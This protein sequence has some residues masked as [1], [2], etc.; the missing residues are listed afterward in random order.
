MQQIIQPNLN[1]VGTI[2]NCL[3]YARRVYGL[4]AKYPT[5]WK[6]WQATKYKHKDQNFPDVSVPCWFSYISGGVNYGHVVVYVPKKGFYSS[7][8]QKGTTR[9]VL[10]SISEIERIYHAKF[11]GWSE[12]INDARVAKPAESSTVIDML[13][14]GDIVNMYQR[15]LGHAPSDQTIK[16]WLGKSGLDLWYRITT[17]PEWK[18][19]QKALTIS[20]QQNG[21][22]TKFQAIKRIVLGG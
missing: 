5:A 1:T 8:W 6:G 14:K 9:A 7:P 19:R 15:E 20:Q 4:P 17:S 13:N 2:G 3:S 12:D 21:D 22:L 10:S 11:V 16:D 18:Q